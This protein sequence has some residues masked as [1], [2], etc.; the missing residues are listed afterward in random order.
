MSSGNY[1]VVNLV[2]GNYR[3]E[4]E[5]TGFKHLTRDNVRVETQNAVRI[6]AIMEVGSVDQKL[7]VTAQTPLLQTE[8][9][10]QGQVVEGR[11][12][13]DMP[14]NGRNVFALIAL[15]P[16]VIPQNGA[17]NGSMNYQ[18]SGG[19]ANQG[20]TWFD[21]APFMNVKLN[22]A[23]FQPIQ[24]LVLEFQV[25]SHSVGPE[26]GGTLN[27]V[28]NLSSKSG[29]NAFHGAAYEYFRNKVLNAS[30]FFSNKAGLPRPAYSQNQ[31]GATMGGPIIKNKTFVF[32]AFEGNRIRSGVTNTVTMPTVAQRGGNFS[33]VSNV[34]Y[35]PST[36]TCGGQGLPSCPAGVTS[37]RTPFPGNIIPAGRLDPTAVL[38]NKYWNLP[39]QSGLTNNLILNYSTGSDA[40]QSSA[41]VDQNISAKQHLF[42]RFTAVN[43]WTKPADTYGTGGHYADEE[44]RPDGSGSYRRYL[45]AESHHRGGSEP[46]GPAKLLRAHGLEYGARSYERNRLARRHRCPV[47]AQGTAADRGDR[48]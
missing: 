2:P 22:T 17:L 3:L 23:A 14:L 11:I 18:I 7:E 21:G 39:N 12:V 29:T 31:F 15:A 48:L 41:R 8:N 1:Q 20:V 26:Y 16:G 13:T 33:G 9:A 43:P 19:L 42:L 24:D 37:G 32:L 10:T 47:G 46:L 25:M 44:R 28:I 36:T 27:G 30:T 5:K 38:L 4:I 45:R 35:D 34:I 40:N 6:D